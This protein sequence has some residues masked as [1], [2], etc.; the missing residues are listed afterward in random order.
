MRLLYFILVFLISSSV[1]SQ[2]EIL[3]RNYFDRGDYEKAISI[4]EKLYKESPYKND[5]MMKL[6]EAHQQLE[7]F[8]ASKDVLEKKLN[9]R[10]PQNQYKVDLG[11]NYA[12]QQKDSIA[13]TYYTEA[14]AFIQ[15]KPNYASVIAKRLEAYSLLDEAIEAYEKGM[16]LNPD[17]NYN[18]QL[19][20]IYGEQG[21]LEKMFLKYINAVKFQQR[22]KSTAQRNF[23]LYITEDSNNEANIILRKILIKKLQEGPDVL[24]NEFLSW[25]FIQQK[26]FNKAF[27]QE[28][29]IYKRMGDGDLVDISNLAIIALSE[30]DYESAEEVIN[31]VIEKSATQDAKLQGHQYLM[32]IRLAT[33]TEKE[34]QD[35]ITAFESLLD[36]FG[37]GKETY[38]LQIDYNHFLAFQANDIESATKNL[39]ALADQNLNAYQESRVKMELADILVFDEKFNRALIYYSQIQKKVQSD[40]LAQEARFKVARTSYFKG[41]F[42]WAKAQVDVLRKS[43]T[44]LI[45]NDALQMAL[46]IHDNTLEDSLQTALK[47]FA[48]ADLLAFQNKDDE[49]IIALSEILTNHKGEKIEDEALLKQGELYEKT[50]QFIKAEANYLKLIEFYRDEILADDALYKLANLYENELQDPQKAK[51][52]YEQIIFD[53]ADS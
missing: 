26:D 2:S 5:F 31:F 32:K 29:A 11:H 27:T 23:S 37:R 13:T 38:L 9:K 50:G 24:Y 19:A 48:R 47:K 45:A 30:K 10:N 34:Y 6:V 7:N 44:Q 43:S 20:R 42:V 39:K 12:L 18:L 17:V 36:Q 14:L 22:F 8:D 16:E 15:E 25:L 33:A 28:K 52:Y 3:A 49:A 21:K 41:D 46:M 40:V 35:I 51:D 1:F 4:Y 53:F